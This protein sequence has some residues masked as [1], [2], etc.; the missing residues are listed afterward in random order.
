MEIKPKA[1]EIKCRTSDDIKH[2]Q[3]SKIEKMMQYYEDNEKTPRLPILT[4]GETNNT[5]KSMKKFTSKLYEDDGWT[6]EENEKGD[7]YFTH[8][9]SDL[10]YSLIY[11]KFG[12]NEYLEVPEYREDS[13]VRGN[14]INKEPNKANPLP[15]YFSELT[16]R[17][18]MN[19][20]GS[21][22]VDQSSFSDFWRSRRGKRRINYHYYMKKREEKKQLYE[23]NKE[24]SKLQ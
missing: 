2:E 4:S 1:P 7:R 23:S 19:F 10:K 9:Y 17:S 12:E 24:S 3:A 8:P 18:K 6:L 15:W 11:K 5:M 22:N 16:Y 20:D 14:S 13:D 21:F